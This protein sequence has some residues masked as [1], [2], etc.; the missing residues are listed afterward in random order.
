MCSAANLE[1]GLKFPIRGNHF[2]PQALRRTLTAE[3][4]R[5]LPFL[6]MAARWRSLL[7]KLSAGLRLHD[8]MRIASLKAWPSIH[9]LVLQQML[10]R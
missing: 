9:D 4:K 5:R 1:G 7:N 6:K 2:R 10:T 8:D 3:A